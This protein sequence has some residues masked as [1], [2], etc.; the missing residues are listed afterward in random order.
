[1]LF[2]GESSWLRFL[3]VDYLLGSG[4]RG[5]DCLLLYDN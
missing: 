1:M 4:V 5:G 2:G 3:V